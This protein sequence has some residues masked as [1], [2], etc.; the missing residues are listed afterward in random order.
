MLIHL[1]GLFAAAALLVTLI[2]LEV[3][4]AGLEVRH[5]GPDTGQPVRRR[6]LGPAVGRGVLAVL[7]GMYLFLFVP[8]LLGLLA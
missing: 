4:H 7:W 2:A 3:R 8:R 6:F 5:A 1:A